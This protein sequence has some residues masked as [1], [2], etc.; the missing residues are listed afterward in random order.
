MWQHLKITIYGKVQDVNFR[1][2]TKK[3]ADMLGIKGFIENVDDGS[4][5]T[6]VEGGARDLEK[7]I[8]WCRKG[9]GMAKVEKINSK[10]SK[11]LKNFKD[12]VI[13]I[14]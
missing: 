3:E 9:P 12:F 11:E 4:V 6:E 1:L 14:K 2:F 10:F 13:K 5:Y 7:F 8:E